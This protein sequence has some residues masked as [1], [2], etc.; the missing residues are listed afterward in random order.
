LGRRP[1]AQSVSPPHSLVCRT[2][3]IYPIHRTQQDCV[4][5]RI[6][7]YRRGCIATDEETATECAE[8]RGVERGETRARGAAAGCIRDAQARTRACPC[9]RAGRCYFKTYGISLRFVGLGHRS[10]WTFEE[11]KVGGL[12]QN[13]NTHSPLVMCKIS[14]LYSELLYL[15]ARHFLYSFVCALVM[16]YWRDCSFT[17][18]QVR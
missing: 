3:I 12:L 8:T 13:Y 6:Y 15:H 14:T 10:S 18:S 5:G 7:S 17:F 4:G 1:P 16:V 2:E 11:K 9:S